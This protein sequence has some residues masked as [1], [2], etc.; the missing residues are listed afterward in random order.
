MLIDFFVIILFAIDLFLFSAFMLLRPKNGSFNFRGFERW[1]CFHGACI[2][3]IFMDSLL[4]IDFSTI[5]VSLIAF[6]VNLSHLLGSC[7]KA[8]LN[9]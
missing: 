2:V 7:I 9:Q 1:D 3:T 6:D 4:G 8:V 5:N